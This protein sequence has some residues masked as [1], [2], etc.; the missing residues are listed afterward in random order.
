LEVVNILIAIGELAD[1]AV[2]FPL[3]HPPVFACDVIFYVKVLLRNLIAVIDFLSPFSFVFGGF[4]LDR[5][6]LVENTDQDII[7]NP[8]P[9]HDGTRDAQTTSLGVQLL[10]HDCL[11]IRRHGHDNLAPGEE[12][13]E[14]VVFHDVPGPVCFLVL[15][16]PLSSLRYFI[17]LT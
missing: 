3:Q 2:M 7:S 8:V 15:K 10:G 5:F 12:A 13:K 1:Q 11:V 9:S 4:L 14:P 6:G 16:T 17:L